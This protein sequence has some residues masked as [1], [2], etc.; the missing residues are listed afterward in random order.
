[1]IV[2]Q[3]D[4]E[5]NEFLFEHICEY[6]P[7]CGTPLIPRGCVTIP[8]PETTN[9]YVA[10]FKDGNWIIVEDH[11][12]KEGWIEDQRI[13]I[14][15]LGPLPDGFSTDVPDFEKYKSTREKNRTHLANIWDKLPSYMR[16]CFHTVYIGVVDLL[17]KNQDDAAIDLIFY[18]NPPDSFSEEQ[19]E[20]FN[21]IKQSMLYSIQNINDNDLQSL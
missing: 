2:Y 5:T 10:V 7:R 4:L 1:M 21:S 13:I 16:G 18:C 9:G 20:M 8:P 3:T 17:E 6:G 19:I 15:N 14:E 11:R 12:G